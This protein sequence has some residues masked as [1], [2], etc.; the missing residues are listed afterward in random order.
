MLLIQNEVLPVGDSP[1]PILSRRAV[2]AF[3]RGSGERVSRRGQSAG[4]GRGRNGGKYLAIHG[5]KR[6]GASAVPFGGKGREQE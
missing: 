1:R 4:S 2:K 6:R 3:R 5:S